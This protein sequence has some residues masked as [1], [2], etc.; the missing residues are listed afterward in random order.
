MNK[1]EAEELTNSMLIADA[2]L[3]LRAV[4][5]LLISKGIF[6]QEELHQ[7]MGV[8]TSQIAKSLLEK[9]NV[10]GDLDELIKGLQEN[11]KKSTGN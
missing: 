7:E 8:V 2:L 6:T 3:R 5:N 9:A 4:E 1:Q 11:N 10:S